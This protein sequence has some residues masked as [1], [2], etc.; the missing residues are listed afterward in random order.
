MEYAVGQSNAMN[1]WR[2]IL[3]LAGALW[4]G[5]MVTI[6]SRRA[7]HQSW[8]LAFLAALTI[9]G[10]YG[11]FLTEVL[12][13]WRVL[14]L[15]GLVLGW[16]AAAVAATAAATRSLGRPRW[17]VLSMELTGLKEKI[18]RLPAGVVF[19]LAFIGFG[20]MVLGVIAFA[21]APNTADALT[22]HL[23][24]VMH[25]QQNQ[26]MA[27]YATPI[28]RQ[29][30]FGPMS[31]IGML[32]YQILAGSDR[33]VNFVQFFAMIG[34]LVGVSVIA[35]LLGAGVNGQ[36]FA[37]LAAMT[38]P[39]GIL[40]ATSTQNDYGA[41]FWSLCVMAFVVAQLKNE[42]SMALIMLTGGGVGL[43]IN[44]KAT[45]VIYLAFIGAWY[46]L[47]AA[48]RLGT[49][50]WKP[51]IVIALIAIPILLPQAWRNSRLYG[52]VLGVAPGPELTGTVNEVASPRLWASNIVRNVADQLATPSQQ[53]N[54]AIE[55]IATR[56]HGLLGI[57]VNSPLSTWR[58]SHFRVVFT[59]HEDSASNPLALVL[60]AVAMLALIVG[61]RAQ[62]WPAAAAVLGGYLLFNV[63]LK[64]QPW[65]SRLEL[66][67]LIMAMPLVGVAA[68]IYAPK[69]GLTAL[70][71][72][73]G[74]ASLPYL[75]ANSTRPLLGKESVLLTDR[76]QQYFYYPSVADA[77]ASYF[78]VAR[79]VNEAGC[80]QVGLVISYDTPEY[81]SWVTL[82]AYQPDVRI[83]HVLVKNSS[84]QYGAAFVPCAII[85]TTGQARQELDYEGHAY[86]RAITAA[87]L[88]LFLA[89]TAAP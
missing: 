48:R 24:R 73:L 51:M 2:P 66:P 70:A 33:L 21:A 43:A 63:V 72:V 3:V 12:G 78:A 40:Q 59:L 19:Q 15:P 26:S 87:P 36:V 58:G 55:A 16:V 39:M 53:M 65:N 27:F 29:L 62:A 32:N 79:T 34:S 50:A 74:L 71:I 4:L 64:W 1:L 61:R 57:D 5:F 23:S 60:V 49:G 68:S 17:A 56:A 54:Q 41:G 67:L 7:L 42:F 80:N 30:A 77:S 11:W 86:S 47:G 13:A 75:F 45:A 25:W 28:Q 84:G 38:V 85:S 9:V 8:R 81:L 18:L 83:E 69:R 88:T 89:T 10:T 52:N 14:A 31:E 35:E 22:Y 37:A 6:A 44:T 20:V 82:R 46:V 76:Q